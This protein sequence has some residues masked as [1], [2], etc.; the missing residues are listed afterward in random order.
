MAT[1]FLVDGPREVPFYKGKGGRTITD[2]NVK[3]FWTRNAE[4]GKRKGY[5]QSYRFN[6]RLVVRSSKT[7]SP[8][9]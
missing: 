6:G 7:C 1:L 8:H 3:A 2:D 5:V 4:I 9:A